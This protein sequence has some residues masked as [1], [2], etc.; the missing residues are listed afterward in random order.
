NSTNLPGAWIVNP[1]DKGRKSIKGNNIYLKNEEEFEIEI[2][3]PLKKSILADIRLNK[4]SISKNGLIIKPGQRVYLD[5]FIDNKK[6]FVF[7]TY[8][9]DNK[10]ESIEAISDNGLI[11][12]F[13]YKEQSVS[14]KNW[15]DKFHKIIIR[16]YYPY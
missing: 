6:K 11:E 10:S 12:V 4:N 1:N 7:K 14:I 5:C 2:F 16:E 15:N 13:F 3:N 9:V 8:D